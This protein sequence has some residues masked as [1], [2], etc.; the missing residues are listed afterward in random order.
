M[1]RATQKGRRHSVRARN[2]QSHSYVRNSYIFWAIFVK[3]LQNTYHQSFSTYCKGVSMALF[4]QGVK[5][6]MIIN[7]FCPEG[8]IPGRCDCSFTKMQSL[9]STVPFQQWTRGGDSLAATAS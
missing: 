2:R 8:K 9:I 1:R 4:C 6:L 5:A 7:M 3:R